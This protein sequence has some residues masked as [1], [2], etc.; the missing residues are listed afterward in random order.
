M[1][2]GRLFSELKFLHINIKPTPLH[3]QI[4]C[5]RAFIYGIG[6]N[7]PEGYDNSKLIKMHLSD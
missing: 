2:F 3:P 5:D 7:F 1:F 4:A 6:L